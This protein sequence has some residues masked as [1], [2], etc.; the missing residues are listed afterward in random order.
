[1]SV[2]SNNSSSPSPTTTELL[3]YIPQLVLLA[4]HLLNPSQSPFP[5]PSPIILSATYSDLHIRISK[6]FRTH[7]DTDFDAAGA[8][9]TIVEMR[10]LMTLVQSAVGGERGKVE[11]PSLNVE[12]EKEERVQ[13]HVYEV[14]EEKVFGGHETNEESN[15]SV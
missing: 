14:V 3:A 1:M 6:Y 8:P 10:T 4:R 11:W 2:T 7:A 12:E 9:H 13:K 5:R 15:A